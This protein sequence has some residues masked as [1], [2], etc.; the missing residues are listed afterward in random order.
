TLGDLPQRLARKSLHAD[1]VEGDLEGVQRCSQGGSRR[2]GGRRRGRRRGGGCGGKRAHEADSVFS[3]AGRRVMPCFASSAG[4]KRSRLVTGFGAAW[5]RPQIEA[6]CM[7]R[8][9][10][11][12]WSASHSSR[13]SS[14]SIFSVPTRH[15][16]HWPQDS[17]AK[18]AIRFF[19]TARRS[20]WSEITTTAA[21]P[22]KQP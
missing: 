16:V 9:R 3:A 5:P 18:K 7:T 14:P 6:S 15:G 10:R 20:S 2:R 19:A 4:K 22:M 11:W 12:S 21:E 17:S 8:A 13:S 1:A